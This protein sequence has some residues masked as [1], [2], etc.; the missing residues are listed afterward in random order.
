MSLNRYS[1]LKFDGKIQTMPSISIS[2]RDTDKYVQYN[3]DKNRLDRI[4]GSIYGDDTYGWLILLANKEYSMEFDIPRNTVIRV[5]F[6]LR[7]AEAEFVS[8]LLFSK[9]K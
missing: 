7:D 4:A 9:D 5:P 2:L 8:K 6:P 3:S 1:Y